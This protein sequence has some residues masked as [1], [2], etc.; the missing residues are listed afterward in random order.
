MHA[1]HSTEW[2]IKTYK[3]DCLPGHI[4]ELTGETAFIMACRLLRDD[5]AMIMLEEFGDK[6]LLLVKDKNDKSALDYA[7]KNDF[8]KVINYLTK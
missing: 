8:N 1:P 7:V 4:Y 3:I 6:C 2:L 5:I